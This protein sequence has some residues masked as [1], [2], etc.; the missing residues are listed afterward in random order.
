MSA[1][2][3]VIVTV[4]VVAVVYV[5]ATP[6][7]SCPTAKPGLRLMLPPAPDPES[8]SVPEIEAPYPVPALLIDPPS[9]TPPV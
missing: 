5:P 2:S 6:M 8:A 3:R 1:A 4:G 9:I 7:L